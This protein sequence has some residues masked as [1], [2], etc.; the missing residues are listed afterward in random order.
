M[1]KVV[2]TTA[3]VSVADIYGAPIENLSTR[4]GR[5]EQFVDFRFP[6]PGEKFLR[7][8][9][10]VMVHREDGEG[11]LGG[12]RLIVT[13]RRNKKFIFTETGEVGMPAVGQPYRDDEG[14][15][16]FGREGAVYAEPY[17]L[18]VYREEEVAAAG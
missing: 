10:V 4:L 8:N 12:P 18:L 17:T 2:P 14:N 9:R 1:P 11:K 15:I 13:E 3:T 16:A 5:K 6:T 7:V